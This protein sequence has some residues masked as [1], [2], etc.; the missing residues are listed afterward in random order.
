MSVYIKDMDVP[1][2][3]GECPFLQGYIKTWC[4]LTEK[5]LYADRIDLQ[6]ERH[7]DCPICSGRKRSALFKICV[8]LAVIVELIK[9]KKNKK[10]NEIKYPSPR[11][12]SS[13]GEKNGKK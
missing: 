6:F 11:W 2:T 10:N 12:W 1:K 4:W 9:R 13:E 7:K 8:G 3:C 5:N